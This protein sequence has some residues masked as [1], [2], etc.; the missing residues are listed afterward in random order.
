MKMKRLLSSILCR[1]GL[2]LCLLLLD[3]SAALSATLQVRC[4]R[5]S[6]TAKVTSNLPAGWWA[7]PQGAALRGVTV[8]NVGGQWSLLCLYLTA[9]RKEIGVLRPYPPTYR[10]CRARKAQL[11][12]VC[13]K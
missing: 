7:T 10:R 8:L 4:P 6:V 13:T 1:S 12:F 11:D 9:Q 2:L 5:E 3:V